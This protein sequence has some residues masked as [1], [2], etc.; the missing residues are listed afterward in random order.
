MNAVAH[1][2]TAYNFK[3][4]IASAPQLLTTNVSF[5]S[6]TV[7]KTYMNRNIMNDIEKK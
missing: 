5:V 2:M 7:V 3:N 4:G 6:R 1:G